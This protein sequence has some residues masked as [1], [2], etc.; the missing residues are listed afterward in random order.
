MIRIVDFLLNYNYYFHIALL[1]ALMGTSILLGATKKTIFLK[2]S[3][4]FFFT[5]C[6][7]FL[8][9]NV[10]IPLLEQKQ[11]I[12]YF[13]LEEKRYFID[14]TMEYA[15]YRIKMDQ[16]LSYEEYLKIRNKKHNIL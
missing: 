16:V 4:L 2:I 9:D 14:Y 7:T 6:G 10:I 3:F 8:K 5:Y 1:V 13:Q 12:S 15:F 11:K